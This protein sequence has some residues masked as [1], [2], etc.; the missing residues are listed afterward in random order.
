MASL[1]DLTGGFDPNA[2]FSAFEKGTEM[3][4]RNR[5]EQNRSRLGQL[6]GA[7]SAADGAKAAF[8]MGELDMGMSLSRLAQQQQ[9]A[10]AEQQRQQQIGQAVAGVV[11]PSLAALAGVS[12]NLA[13]QLYGAQ[14]TNAEQAQRFAADQAWR[15]KQYGLDV[16]RLTQSGTPKAP[17]GYQFNG[18]GLEPIPGGPAD[19]T[20][21]VPVRNLRP[22]GD[23]SNAAGFYDR[24]S[25]AETIISDPKFAAAGADQVNKLKAQ[26]PIAGNYM[27]PP[28]FQQFDQAQRDFVNAVLRKESGAAISQS[29]F[30]NAARQYFPQPGDSE[31]V[32]RQKTRNRQIAIAAMKRTAGPALAQQGAATAPAAAADAGAYPGADGIT[33]QDQGGGFTPGGAINEG[34]LPN[35][36][37]EAQDAIAQGADPQAVVQALIDMGVDPTYAGTLANGQ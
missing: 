13:V 1:S 22:T 2:M 33:N 14:Q 18:N 26:V 34:D 27:V 9:A 12:P 19:P 5:A 15:E 23:Q 35:A 10:M 36:M 21:P 30:D 28:E 31:V 16:Q 25:A 20:R 3:A 17:A 37:Q 11:P 8:S 24:M 7:G 4:Q 6:L 32:I 29:E